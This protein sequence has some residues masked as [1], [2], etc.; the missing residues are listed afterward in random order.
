MATWQERVKADLAAKQRAPKHKR[1]NLQKL[2]RKKDA[3]GR[4]LRTARRIP[5]GERDVIRVSMPAELAN[6]ILAEARD[7]NYPYSRLIVV[8]AALGLPV[9]QE[10]RDAIL[11][12]RREQYVPKLVEEVV[13][14]VF[15]KQKPERQIGWRSDIESKLQAAALDTKKKRE[16]VD[17]TEIAMRQFRGK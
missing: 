1:L 14:R 3:F 11:A 9:F 13:K 15:T 5:E 4:W 6:K 12:N 7:N 2:E 10:H 8:L 17:P 16:A